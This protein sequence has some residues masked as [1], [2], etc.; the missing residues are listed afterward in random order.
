MSS[1]EF[2]QANLKKLIIAYNTQVVL[3]AKVGLSAGYVSQL[4]T[5]TRKMGDDVARRIESVLELPNSWMDLPHDGDSAPEQKS[6]GS[7]CK[8]EIDWEKQ[9][10]LLPELIQSKLVDIKLKSRSKLL[11]AIVY[12]AQNVQNLERVKLAKLLYLLDFTVFAE[13]N[14]NVTGLDYFAWENGPVPVS[15]FN[16]LDTPKP[17]LMRKISFNPVKTSDGG[18]LVIEA[19]TDFDSTAFTNF[20]FLTIKEL[21]EKYN[22]ALAKDMLDD[23]QAYPIDPWAMVYY[24]DENPFGRIPYEYSL[25]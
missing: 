17:D 9:W 22:D 13:C 2:R 5:G 10:Y 24:N 15:L 21:A 3:A 4:V 8:K 19:K 1:K 12:F 18:I 6:Q 11:N 16:E 14:K 7:R 23:M 20:E 25:D